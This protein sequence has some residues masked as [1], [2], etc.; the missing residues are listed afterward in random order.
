MTENITGLDNTQCFKC[1]ASIK[2]VFEFEGKPY[3][4]T[5]VE[6]VSGIHPSK[7]QWVDGKGDEKAT[8][9]SLAEKEA[10][11]EALI[12]SNK[13]ITAKREEIQAANRVRFAELIEALDFGSKSPGDFCH[14][15]ARSI[16][17]DGSTTDL[18]EILGDRPYNIVR[19][20]WGKQAGRMN[21]KKYE[22]AVAI[23][24]EKYDDYEDEIE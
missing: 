18:Y 8:R 2:Y 5:C 9:K 20:I 14:N 22:A 11:R 7:W 24:D 12:E 10:E 3:G 19:E 4:S 1:G 6:Y 17:N 13:A 21:S 15:M 16:E 23:F